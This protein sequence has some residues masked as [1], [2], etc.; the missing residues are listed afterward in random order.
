MSSTGPTFYTPRPPGVSL[1]PRGRPGAPAAPSS[2]FRQIVF[3]FGPRLIFCVMVAAVL[4][5][6]A[7]V[8]GSGLGVSEAAIIAFFGVASVMTVSLYRRMDLMLLWVLMVE[9]TIFLFQIVL[10]D[11]S[12][13][14][15]PAIR[16][17]PVLVAA[18]VF[19]LAYRGR[20]ASMGLTAILWV[21]LSLPIL[22]GA[23]F[24]P[25]LDVSRD[26]TLF[27]LNILYPV[28]V[29]H[30]V[31]SMPANGADSGHT[32]EMLS[33][34]VIAMAV[35]PLLLIPIELTLRQGGGFAALQFGGRAYAVI[36]II[37]L[38]WPILIDSLRRWPLAAAYVSFAVIALIIATSFSRGAIMA[39]ALLLAATLVFGQGRE[40][41]VM[42]H[43]G[44]A[45]VL[46]GVASLFFLRDWFDQL[47]WFWMLRTN[48]ASNASAQVAFNAADF[49]SS[50]RGDI[51]EM[52]WR[53]F[54]EK[55]LLGHGIG[56]TPVLVAEATNN[57][58]TYS[59]MHN[60]L[61]TVLVERG[62]IGTVAVLYVL[63]RI[64]TLIWRGIKQRKLS[65]VHMAAF[66]I[67][68][69]FANTTGVELFMNSTRL[70]NVTATVYLL[71]YLAWLEGQVP[72]MARTARRPG[73]PGPG[74]WRGM[75]RPQRAP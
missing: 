4:G 47:S 23:L 63:L 18:L 48:M 2:L 16:L 46:V 27:A 15:H 68:L 71:A 25:E 64:P 6:A 61:L 22:I 21:G 59:G 36:G 11:I 19:T 55:P 43:L 53:L 75:P 60:M 73:L 39:T 69:L 30:A 66:V 45:S 74:Q 1:E 42:M 35:V 33:I 56:T 12:V 50:G 10:Y 34:S 20:R 38:T 32:A 51:W 24:G 5:L 72:A 41:K 31:R 26:L 62:L 37:L 44:L 65:I 58:F 8:F 67:F 3:A 14:M 9:A 49:F 29:Y 70:M 52:G 17:G 7:T 54:Q 28:G 13:E 57:V 40:R